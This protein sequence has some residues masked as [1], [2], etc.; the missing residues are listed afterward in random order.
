MLRIV[1]LGGLGHIGGNMMAIETD[2]S[3]VLIDC[4]L[5]FPTEDQPGVDYVIPDVSYVV[6]RLAKL[7]AILLTHGH[8]DHIG[9]LPYLWEK[10]R[11][12]VYGTRFTLG[13]LGAKL[14]EFPD[15]IPPLVTLRDGERVR[16]DD[17]AI[18]PIAVTH[19]IPGAVAFAIETAAGVL[20][21]TGDFKIDETPLDGRRTGVAALRARGDAGVLALLSDSTNSE[22]QGH[23]YGESAVAATLST[24]IAEAP[25]RVVVTSF[26]SNIFRLRS[27]IAAAEAAGRKVVLAGRSVEQNVRLAIEQGYIQTLPGTLRDSDEFT[28]LPR[29]GVVV[30]AG[31]SQGEPQSTFSRIAMA[32]HGDIA[33]EPGDRVILSSRRIPGNERSVAAVVNNLCRLGVEVI[34]DRTS[35]VHASGHAFTDEQRAMIEWCR[36]RFFVPIHGEYRHLSRHAALARACGVAAQNIFI[37]EDGQPLEFQQRGD[38][39]TARR[40]DP[41]TAGFVYVESKRVGDVGETVLRDRRVLAETGFVLCVVVLDEAGRIVAGPHIV[42]RGLML[43]E[44]GQE[45]LAEAGDA[46][47]T[48]L[49]Q[50]EPHADHATRANEVRVTLRRYFRRELERRPLV[51]PVVMA[52]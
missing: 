43:E 26:A 8:E 6:E 23:T 36:P 28:L 46:V 51:I 39:T 25:F 47:R 33:V 1:P 2:V 14:T 18:E 12:P 29:S 16:F 45:I 13:L 10:L 50:L 40:S 30:I 37:M 15:C 17:I 5:L 20:V 48:A 9:A 31:G 21:H 24:L 49:E 19:S 35:C 22:R 3:M 34:D 42:T 52:I 38:A 27:I 44:E 32:K 11:V 41:V 4:G 7:R